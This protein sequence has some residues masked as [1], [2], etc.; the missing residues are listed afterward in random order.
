ME[1][2]KMEKW[3]LEDMTDISEMDGKYL[4][5]WTE[6]QIFG[7]PIADVVQIVGIQEITSMPEF[8]NYAKGVINLRGSIIPVID[9][10]LRFNK[11]EM[12]YNER[13][14]IVVT[15][16]KENLIGFIVDEVDEVVKIEAEQISKPPQLASERSDAQTNL[17]GIGK[18]NGKIVLL[19]N[20]EA[21]LSDETIDFL[22]AAS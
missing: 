14:C 3:T 11:P 15:N 22:T 10:R 12:P 7:I 20:T 16:I 8:P 1:E 6:S 9:V 2:N 13:T 4:T 18:L 5:F 19:I 21:L 17:E